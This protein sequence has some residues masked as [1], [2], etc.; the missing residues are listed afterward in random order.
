MAS[1]ILY[2]TGRLE[3]IFE[4]NQL[5]C[6]KNNASGFAATPCHSTQFWSISLTSFFSQA[7]IMSDSDSSYPSSDSDDS[8]STPPS[9]YK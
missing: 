2:E 6:T 8:D 3:K 1:N 5:D 4:L 7:A 9:G